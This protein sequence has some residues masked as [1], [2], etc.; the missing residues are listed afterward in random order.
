MKGTDVAKP[1]ISEQLNMDDIRK[2]REYN[3]LRHIKMTYNEIVEDIKKG[4]AELPAE[5]RKDKGEGY[6]QEKR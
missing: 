2:I 3:S 1:V 5:L 4:A 6:S